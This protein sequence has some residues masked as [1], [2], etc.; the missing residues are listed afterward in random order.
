MSAHA[1]ILARLHEN[2]LSNTHIAGDD[3]GQHQHSGLSTETPEVV[4]KEGSEYHKT[5]EEHRE[6]GLAERILKAAKMLV[7]TPDVEE[8]IRAAEELKRMHG[9]TE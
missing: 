8:I 6:V 1:H 3:G 4:K 5:G 7:A 9:V 2:T